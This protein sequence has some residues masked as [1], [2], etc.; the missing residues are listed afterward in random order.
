MWVRLFI[1]LNSGRHRPPYT[2]T[3]RQGLLVLNLPNLSPP[4]WMQECEWEET[5]EH[6]HTCERQYNC[7]E[8]W[9]AARYHAEMW[10]H[11]CLCTGGQGGIP[12]ELYSKRLKTTHVILFSH[13]V[14]SKATEHHFLVSHWNGWSA[15]SFYWDNSLSVSKVKNVLHSLTV[16][17]PGVELVYQN[18]YS[19]TEHHNH[20]K[21]LY[22]SV[23]MRPAVLISNS[24]FLSGMVRVAIQN[25][26]YVSCADP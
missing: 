7:E 15:F 18:I 2:A 16:C 22:S 23:Q 17:R 13:N 1:I 8:L 6:T 5:P 21:M 9:G 12:W 25:N 4:G 24:I 11:M 14:E 26:L 20:F 19:A 10:A 3:W